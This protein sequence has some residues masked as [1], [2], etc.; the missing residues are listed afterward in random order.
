MAISYPDGWV[1][2][3]ERGEKLVLDPA[4]GLYE[5]PDGAQQVH[6]EA[7]ALRTADYLKAEASRRKRRLTRDDERLC[8]DFVL[9]VANWRTGAWDRRAEAPKASRARRKK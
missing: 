3:V 1:V 2:R 6:A 9:L 7:V 5:S 8:R 4:T